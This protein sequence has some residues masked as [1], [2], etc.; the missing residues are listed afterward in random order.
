MADKIIPCGGFYIDTGSLAF[1]QHEDRKVLTVI[2]GGGTQGDLQGDGKVI[3]VNGNTITIP[4]ADNAQAG[5]VFVI[6]ADGKSVEWVFPITQDA[7]TKALENY[8]TVSDLESGR[9]NL[10]TA[11]DTTVGGI[12]SSAE[13]NNI[14]V[15]ADGTAT[16]NSLSTAKLMDDDSIKLVLNGGSATVGV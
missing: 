12:K 16:V 10:P 8:V 7:L 6:G 5:Q 11:T 3:E 15:N 2:G 1:V 9:V 13:K 14:A 4:G